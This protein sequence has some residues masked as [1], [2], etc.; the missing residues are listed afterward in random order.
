V[1]FHE[2]SHSLPW[3]C[4]PVKRKRVT[5]P[6][7]FTQARKEAISANRKVQLDMLFEKWDNDGSGY[8]DLDEVEEIMMKYKEG[9]EKEVI[10]KG[11]QGRH[12]RCT[13]SVESSFC[14]LSVQC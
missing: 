4:W 8:L 7:L 9:Q 10:S 6:Y 11:Q 2:V 5:L 1:L 13:L 14:S 3:F 12:C